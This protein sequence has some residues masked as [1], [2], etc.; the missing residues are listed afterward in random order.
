MHPKSPIRRTHSPEFKAL[1]LAA[2]AQPGTSVAAVALSHGLNANVVR[3]WLSGRG[4]KRCGLS[5]PAGQKQPTVPMQFVPVGLTAASP[6]VPCGLRP[7][8]RLDLD[9]GAL[10]VK[11]H[12][13]R[14]AGA[15]M[16]AVL[17][18]LAQMVE[19]A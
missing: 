7:D 4:M 15:S 6:G 9:L 3:K 8:I 5:V 14:V 2:C 13:A 18:S 19:R 17:Y 10:Q 11:L 12:C 16:A 1:V